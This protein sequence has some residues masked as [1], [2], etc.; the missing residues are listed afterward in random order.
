MRRVVILLACTV[1]LS[2]W[3]ASA[4]TGAEDV[5]RFCEVTEHI[6]GRIPRGTQPDPRQD[7]AFA[8]R[9][10]RGY[11]RAAE[12]AHPVIATDARALANYFRQLGKAGTTKE[13]VAI[14]NQRS[15]AIT[16]RMERFGAYVSAKCLG[17]PP[18][19]TTFP[20]PFV[21]LSV[22]GEGRATVT[23]SDATGAPVTKSVEVPWD[24][25]VASGPGRSVRLSATQAGNGIVT[26]S[27]R[28]SVEWQSR[29]TT[30]ASDTQNGDHVTA[31]CEGTT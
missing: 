3:A 26:C 22:G 17:F 16:P 19:T 11:D 28:Y 25:Y 30:V 12:Y 18:T 21:S 10:S 29:G 5:D 23:Y 1:V 6:G 9:L 13:A 24:T 20:A 15:A 14:A 31:T 7:R 27:I 8:S 4:A 2:T